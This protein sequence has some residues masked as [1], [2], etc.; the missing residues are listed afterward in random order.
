MV[1]NCRVKTTTSSAIHGEPN[2][3]G[4]SV[5]EPLALLAMLF[6]FGWMRCCAG[7]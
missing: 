7:G 2:W 4:I 5:V 1:A 3:A 6:A